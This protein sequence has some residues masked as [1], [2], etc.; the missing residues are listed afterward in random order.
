MDAAIRCVHNRGLAKVNMRHV[1]DAAGLAR[2]TAYKYYSN[3]NDVL[4]DAF[5][6]EGLTYAMQLAQ[7]IESVKGVDEQFVEA[8]LYVVETLPQN[9]VLMLLVRPEDG[10]ISALGI[11]YHP[12]GL[13]GQ[14]AFANIF[15]AYPALAAQADDI[16]ELWARNVLSFITLRGIRER[17]R[18]E[19]ADYVRHR[20]LPGLHLH[21]LLS[22]D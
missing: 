5:M 16:S 4:A 1:A 10:F 18:T 14:F 15:R 2:Q 19:L 21:Q 9:P 3:K 11:S 7:H 13:F 20:L 22:T 17:S 12:F 8:F 6:R